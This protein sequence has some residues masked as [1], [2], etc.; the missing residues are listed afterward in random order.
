MGQQ[1]LHRLAVPGLNLERDDCSRT[2]AEHH[3]LATALLRDP[4]GD[5]MGVGLQPHG[6]VLLALDRA[7]AI[8]AAAI[9]QHADREARC[10]ASG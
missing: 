1:Q 10:C 3:R 2:A 7:G 8:A 9:G 5:V 6:I 4:V